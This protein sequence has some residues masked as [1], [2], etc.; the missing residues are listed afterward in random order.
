M[1]TWSLA[2]CGSMR[3]NSV[4]PSSALHFLSLNTCMLPASK[5]E[6]LPIRLAGSVARGGLNQEAYQKAWWQSECW[7]DLAECQ[8]DLGSSTSTC[9]NVENV[10]KLQAEMLKMLKS[11][12][13]KCWKLKKYHSLHRETVH[14]QD[15]QHSQHFN[16]STFQL[17]NFHFRHSQHFQLSTFQQFSIPYR[18]LWIFN[19]RKL[20]SWKLKCWKCRSVEM[21]QVD[22]SWKVDML[23]VEKA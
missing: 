8:Q 10:E 4:L 19:L 6:G 1:V 18:I 23:K 11:W 14:F 5:F 3:N 7:L 21:L 9:W 17:F 22:K 20:K 2:L 13:L 15:F 16:I 12:K